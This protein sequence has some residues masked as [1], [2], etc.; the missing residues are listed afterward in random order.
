MNLNHIGSQKKIMFGLLICMICTINLFAQQS[1]KDTIIL[2]SGHSEVV[3]LVKPLKRVAIANPE[4][5]DAS[6][7]SETQIVIIGKLVGTT[8]MIVWYEDDDY[9]KYT[10]IIRST[11]SKEQVILKVRFMEVNKSGLKEFGSDFI[12]KN[13]LAG[14]EKIDIGSFGGKVVQPNDPLLLSSTV[15]FF[16]NIPSRNVSSVFKALHEKNLISILASPNLSA[17][18]GEEA[19]FL[20]GGEFPIPIVSGSM[21]MQTVTIHYKEFGVKLKFKPV[22]LDTN[23]ININVLAEVSSLDFENGITLSGFQIPSLVTRKAETTVELEK[24]QYLI[25]GGLL[26]NEMTQT[27]AKVPVLGHVPILGQLFSSK[28]YL[29]KESELVIALSPDIVYS[30]H[31]EEVPELHLEEDTK[32]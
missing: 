21:G 1:S 9:I 7:I 14:D 10:L 6:V 2:R 31:E 26:S 4:V 12:V 28:R 16:F 13:I 11:E 23:L 30:I 25:I 20:A 32:K 24:G 27:V 18:S 17:L 22:V 8:S 29:N 19:S 5:A 3:D 15:D